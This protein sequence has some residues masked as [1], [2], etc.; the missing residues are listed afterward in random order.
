MSP[1]KS[2][3]ENLSSDKLNHLERKYGKEPKI[4]IEELKRIQW[5]WH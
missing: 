5:N 4:S 3:K 1:K 2:Q